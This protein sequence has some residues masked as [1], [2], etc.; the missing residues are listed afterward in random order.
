MTQYIVK[1]HSAVVLRTYGSNR[2]IVNWFRHIC[3]CFFKADFHD[4]LMYDT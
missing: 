1:L 4:V 3:A 2:E